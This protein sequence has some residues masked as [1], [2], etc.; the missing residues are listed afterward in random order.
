MPVKWLSSTEAVILGVEPVV[1]GAV[2][3]YGELT[4]GDAIPSAR[5]FPRRYRSGEDLATVGEELFMS[6][7]EGIL[8][9]DKGRSGGGS[10]T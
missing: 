5:R 3:P 8:I 10:A 6:E 2:D 9:V 7:A 4:V 1:V